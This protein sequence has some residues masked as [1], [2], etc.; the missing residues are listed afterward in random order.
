MD[1]ANIKGKSVLLFVL[2]G[3]YVL[4][5]IPN[6][7]SIILIPSIDDILPMEFVRADAMLGTFEEFDTE[8]LPVT[9]TEPDFTDNIPILSIDIPLNSLIFV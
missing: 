4:D 5:L 1:N 8:T 6:E 9:I 2:V 7:L 3:Y